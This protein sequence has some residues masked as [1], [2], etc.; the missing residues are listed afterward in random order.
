MH[1][2][3][4]VVPFFVGPDLVGVVPDDATS[5]DGVIFIRMVVNN[6][7]IAILDLDAFQTLHVSPSHCHP[8]PA[9]LVLYHLLLDCTLF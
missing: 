3:R 5:Q 8:L 4:M 6:H 2:L 7:P 9:C 1:F